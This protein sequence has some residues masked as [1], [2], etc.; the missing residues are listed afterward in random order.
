MGESRNCQRQTI[1]SRK[2]WKCVGSIWDCM[3]CGTYSGRRAGPMAQLCMVRGALQAKRAAMRGMAVCDMVKSVKTNLMM[4][5]S[6][7]AT[8]ATELPSTGQDPLSRAVASWQDETQYPLY[9][10]KT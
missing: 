4:D 9:G 7:A 10:T 2:S 1:G 8:A 6:T 3:D 5:G